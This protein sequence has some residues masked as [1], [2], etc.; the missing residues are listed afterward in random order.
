MMLVESFVFGVTGTRKGITDAQTRWLREQLAYAET[1]HHGAC[2]GADE[3]AHT[4]ALDLGSSIVVHPPENTRLMAEVR[5]PP[6]GRSFVICQSKP[7]LERNHDI[8]D[9]SD[10]LLALPDG[11]ERPKSGTWATVRYAVRTGKPVAICYPD[12]TVEHR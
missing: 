7:Y 2:V 9:A 11:P 10:R 8:V 6:R 3:A 12:G 5:T 4:I 1:L